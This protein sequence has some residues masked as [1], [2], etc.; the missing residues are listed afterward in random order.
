MRLKIPGGGI[1]SAGQ[2]CLIYY[3]HMSTTT[4]K[5]IN[6]RKVESNGDNSVI[7]TVTSVPVNAWTQRKVPFNAIATGYNVG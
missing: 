3:Y 1:P 6:V 7:D 4:T 5:S 2:Q